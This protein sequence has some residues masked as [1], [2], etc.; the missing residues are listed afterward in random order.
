M[1][2]SIAFFYTKCY[3]KMKNRVTLLKNPKPV[4]N[5][6]LRVQKV[7]IKYTKTDKNI[8]IWRLS[9]EEQMANGQKRK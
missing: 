1:F 5:I 2:K 3:N 7:P 4:S 8:I 6:W 9:E